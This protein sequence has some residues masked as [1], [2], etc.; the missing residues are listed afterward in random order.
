MCFSFYIPLM[1]MMMIGCSGLGAFKGGCLTSLAAVVVVL[2]HVLLALFLFLFFSF[3]SA[4]VFVLFAATLF[5]HVFSPNI[6]Q[7]GRDSC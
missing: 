5:A 6:Q 3:S 1:M 2:V 7:T 4:V